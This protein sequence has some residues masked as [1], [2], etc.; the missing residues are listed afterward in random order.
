MGKDWDAPWKYTISDTGFAGKNY[1]PTPAF[2]STRN[3]VCRVCHRMKRGST[4]HIPC[5]CEQPDF[6][7]ADAKRDDRQKFQDWCVTWLKECY[8]VL[9]PG[10]RIKVFGG[11]RM[12]HRMEA[13]VE[14]AGFILL[15]EEA[16]GYGSGFPKSLNL[17]KAIDKSLGKS[18]DREVVGPYQTPEGGQEL[19]TYNNWQ[20]DSLLTGDQGRRQP[21]VTTAA[22]SEAKR[23]EGFGTALKPAWEPFVVGMKP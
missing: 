17:S 21:M 12:K 5:D 18:E 2:Q 23:F 19:T 20:S 15:A 10:G 7:D 3:P 14:Q 16:W 8:R 6:D 9:V 1:P 11:T 22:T 4:R 13:A